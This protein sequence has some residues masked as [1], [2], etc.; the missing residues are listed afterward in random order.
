MKKGKFNLDLFIL[1]VADYV[2]VEWL[3]RNNCYS[4]FIANF[5]G[6]FDYDSPR[7]AIRSHLFLILRSRSMTLRNAISAAFMFPFT[8][9][10]MDYWLSIEQRWIDF[11]DE[12]NVE[13]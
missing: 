6:N 4:K 10:G 5:S 2:F 7:E 3:V 8:P 1:D 9:E 11:L 13:L 12:F